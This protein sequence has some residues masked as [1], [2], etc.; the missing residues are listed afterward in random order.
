MNIFFAFL[1]TTIAGLSTVL[2]CFIIFFKGNKD[3]IIKFS[4]TFAA[5]VMIL[6]SIFDLIP[7][8]YNMFSNIKLFPTLILILISINIGIIISFYIDKY[9]PLNDNLYRV[10]VISMIGIILHNI[11]EGIATFTSSNTDIN[12]GIRLTIA[13]SLH[14]IPEGIAI[15]I[16]IYYSTNSKIKAFIYTFISGLSEV[17]G[18]VITYLFLS[19]YMNNII[20]GILFS[21]IAGL[22]IYIS[23][24]EIFKS[25]KKEKITYKAI[26]LAII[27]VIIS[28]LI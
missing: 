22:M 2:G 27:I 6:I 19:K 12:L 11:P 3:K 21:V 8:S 23:V 20:L 16:P 25:L 9:I 18:A 7:E 5:S 4:L 26:F 14:N 13:I 28:K 1:L 15:G 24:F 10:G 17:L